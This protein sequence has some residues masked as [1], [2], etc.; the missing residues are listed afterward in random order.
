ML[1]C[2]VGH[3]LSHVLANNKCDWYN[4]ELSCCFLA[5]R[6]LISSLILMVG[7][8]FWVCLCAGEVFGILILA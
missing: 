1:S 6:Y 5:Y 2:I 4:C 3:K 8:L 7:I